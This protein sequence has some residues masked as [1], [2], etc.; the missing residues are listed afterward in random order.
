MY[1]DTSV[2]E[3]S[4]SSV[5]L[6]A[7][8]GQSAHGPTP[9]YVAAQSR[10]LRLLC[11]SGGIVLCTGEA[12]ARPPGRVHASSTRV[13]PTRASLHLIAQR[14]AGFRTPEAGILLRSWPACA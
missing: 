8:P 10:E 4:W 11:V 13:A 3:P 14:T 12:G 9:S 2:Y 6:M 1:R 7:M 5:R